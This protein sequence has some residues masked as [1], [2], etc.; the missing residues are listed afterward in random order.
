MAAIRYLGSSSAITEL[1]ALYDKESSKA[2]RMQIVRSLAAA[3]AIDR[4]QQIARAENDQEIRLQAI[5]SFAAV[6][7][8]RTGTVL[9][10]MYTKESAPEVKRAII[11]ALHS[12]NN[13]EGLVA[14]ARRENDPKMKEDIVRR[15]STMTKSK[16]ALDYLMELLNK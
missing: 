6:G 1:G 10:D 7:R 2:I 13:A 5:R 14:V 9:Q 4:L 8:E 12:Q 11:S 15:L 16:V 3:G